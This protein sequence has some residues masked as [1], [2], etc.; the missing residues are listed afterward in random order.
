VSSRGQRS[1]RGQ[2]RPFPTNTNKSYTR[3]DEH[4]SSKHL[5][6]CHTCVCSKSI[7]DAGVAMRKM[8]M[9][10]LRSI[11]KYMYNYCV[12]GLI[13]YS[14]LRIKCTSILL[15]MGLEQPEK[16]KMTRF[17]PNRAGYIPLKI[18][19]QLPSCCTACNGTALSRK[20]HQNMSQNMKHQPID[21]LPLLAFH[22]CAPQLKWEMLI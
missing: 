9:H 15:A 1:L 8:R 5:K 4:T 17:W 14:Y 18:D 21:H 12:T 13:E 7:Y 11:F 10:Y 22:A 6:K 16:N 20:C 2:K 3:C 19:K